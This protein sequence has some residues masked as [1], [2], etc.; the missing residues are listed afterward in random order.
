MYVLRGTNEP[1]WH[2]AMSPLMQRLAIRQ[3]GLLVAGSCALLVVGLGS[4]VSHW[5]VDTGSEDRQFVFNC[6]ESCFMFLCF[7]RP[8]RLSRAHTL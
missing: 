1:P 7:F 2:Y 5:A 6:E 3:A 4:Y 8:E